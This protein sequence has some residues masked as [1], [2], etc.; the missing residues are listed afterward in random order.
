MLVLKGG[1]DVC[2]VQAHYSLPAENL[3]GPSVPPTRQPIW[4]AVASLEDFLLH[5]GS[6]PEFLVSIC[7]LSFSLYDQPINALP[8][9]GR[10]LSGRGRS[11]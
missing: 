1:G 4:S 7:R 2:E 10:I 3:A 11:E 5:E 6:I 9:E 8:Y